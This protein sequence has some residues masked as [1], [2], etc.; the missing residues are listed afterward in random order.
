MYVNCEYATFLLTHCWHI[1]HFAI[2]FFI[3]GMY[4]TVYFKVYKTIYIIGLCISF[5]Y[6]CDI[7]LL[8]SL[9]S[10]FWKKK[11]NWILKNHLTFFS[12]FSLFLNPVYFHL[13]QSYILHPNR[14]SRIWRM[15]QMFRTAATF[16]PSL[17]YLFCLGDNSASHHEKKYK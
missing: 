13:F 12:C 14:W 2:S 4:M 7:F 15:Q 16:L 9:L 5:F 8:I 17:H 10:L 11:Q 3:L 6:H 1:L